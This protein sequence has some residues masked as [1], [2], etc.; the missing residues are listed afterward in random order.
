MRFVYCLAGW[1]GSAHDSRVLR[2]AM[3]RADAF[4]VAAGQYYLAD[5]AFT[6]A[7]GFLTPYRSTRYH[8]T[9]WG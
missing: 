8:L 6:N 9:E 2:D 5:G 1:P 4:S 7:T 3:F